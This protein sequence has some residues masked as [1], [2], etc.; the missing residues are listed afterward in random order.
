MATPARAGGLATATDLRRSAGQH[1]AGY[2]AEPECPSLDAWNA[3]LHARLPPGSHAEELTRRLSIEI[4]RDEASDPR[5]PSYLGAIDTPG[6]ALS[7][8]AR[9]VRG[10]SCR[11][12]LEALSLIAALALE[13]AAKSGRDAGATQGT[14]AGAAASGW[15]LSREQALA[16]SEEP[17][18][19]APLRARAEGARLGLAVFLL[20]EAAAAP[21]PGWNYGLGASVH[22]DGAGWQPWVLFGVYAGGGERVR[23]PDVAAVA[24]F[25]RLSSYAVGCPVR[26]PRRTPLAVRPCIDL[27]LGRLTGEGQDVSQARRRSS[28]WVS[29]G[30]ELRIEWSPFAAFELS[31]MLG[32]VLPLSR[33]RFYFRPQL[34]AWEVAPLGLRAGALA[35]LSF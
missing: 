16:L 23:V 26:F 25:E 1:V 8:E 12:V 11:E 22:W 9:Q 27:D 21:Q 34:T 28:L 13:R 14:D 33:P 4:R 6:Q 29:T 3:A 15:E 31:G 17:A 20:S 18:E 32:G 35:N 5:A 10:Q 7:P 2:H 19:P 24:R 30:L